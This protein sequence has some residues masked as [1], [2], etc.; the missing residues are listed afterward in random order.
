MT[1][2]ITHRAVDILET[3][4]QLVGGDRAKQYGDKRENQQRVADLWNAY[5]GHQLKEPL[6][7]SQV[8]WMLCLLKVARSGGGRPNIDNAVDAAGYA[9]IAGELMDG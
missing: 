3:A 5:L 2:I 9:A 4:A 1:S 6:R 7:V 8:P